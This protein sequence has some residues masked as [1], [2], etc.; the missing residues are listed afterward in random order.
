MEEQ[1]KGTIHKN[2]QKDKLWKITEYKRDEVYNETL[3]KGWF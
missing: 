1:Q 3:Y 2:P